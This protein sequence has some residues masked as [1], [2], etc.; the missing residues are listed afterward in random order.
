MDEQNSC[1]N[2]LE[3]NTYLG[4]STSKLANIFTFSIIVET[5][6]LPQGNVEEPEMRLK[7]E[8]LKIII[9]RLFMYVNSRRKVNTGISSLKSSN[10]TIVEADTEKAEEL[11]SFFKDIF[12]NGNMDNA[13]D[14]D[15]RSRENSVETLTINENL[16]KT[17]IEKLNS[18]K[19]GGPD[20]LHS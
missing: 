18:N 13:P 10:G 11:N 5:E 6:M 7:T 1:Q 9:Q 8:Y 19:S 4:R 3:K 2:R 15:D 20:L 14:F 12:V 16:V 17:L